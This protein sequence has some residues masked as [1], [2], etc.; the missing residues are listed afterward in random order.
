MEEM[1]RLSG[2]QTELVNGV[3]G[4]VLRAAD[5]F[6]AKVRSRLNPGNLQEWFDKERMGALG[7]ASGAMVG[8][9]I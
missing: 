4:K 6:R 2:E 5:D 1:P 8:T 3:K 9:L 7:L